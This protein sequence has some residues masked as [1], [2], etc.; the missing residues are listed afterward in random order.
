MLISI[1]ADVYISS[2]SGELEMTPVLSPVV[3]Q[4]FQNPFKMGHFRKYT[5]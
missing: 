2:T 5:K 1:N 4:G 3:Y